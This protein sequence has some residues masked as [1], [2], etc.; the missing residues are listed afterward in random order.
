MASD[1]PA[2]RKELKAL[3]KQLRACQPPDEPPQYS[4]DVDL[5]ADNTHH[6]KDEQRNW[7]LDGLKHGFDVYVR[8]TVDL[9]RDKVRNLPTCLTRKLATTKWIFGN[10]ANHAIWGPFNKDMSDLP[11]WLKGKLRLS[12]IGAIKKGMHFLLPEHMKKWRVIHHLSHPRGGN[13]VNS[14]VL[15]EWATVQY[16]QFREVVELVHSLGVGALLWTVDAKDAYLRVP[17]NKS[18]MQYMGFSWEGMVFVFTC[19]S[20]GLASAPR[21][22]TLFADAMLSIIVNNSGVAEWWQWNGAPLVYHY[23]DDFFGG[24]PVGADF[25]SKAQFDAVIFWFIKLGVPTTAEKCVEPTTR[26]KILGF[27]Y[28]TIRQ[29]VFIPEGKKDEIQHELEAILAKNQVTKERMQSLVGK[30][31]WVSVCLFAGPAFVRRIEFEINKRRPGHHIKVALFS[32]DLEWWVEQL[33]ASADGIKFVDILRKRSNG[34]VNVWTDA[35]TGDGM[36]GWNKEGQW[37]RF[38][39]DDHERQELFPHP[40]QPDIYWKEMVAI[41]TAAM[42]W[43]HQWEGKAVTFW[44]DN[45]AC[46]W[47]L[48][49]KRCAFERTDVMELIR[50]IAACAN[51]MKFTPYFIHIAGKDNLTADALSRFDVAKF[52]AD[53]AGIEMD[54]DETEC[55]RIFTAL[56]ERSFPKGCPSKK[57]KRKKKGKKS[58]QKAAAAERG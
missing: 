18:S 15:G 47:S 21:I 12:P 53:T 13:S 43:G 23:I 58:K 19:L 40:Q 34:D 28:D 32:E 39:W 5:W 33:A 50:V 35:S 27:I 38:K 17:I 45:E 29:M 41:A 8:P 22:Y 20:F 36:G 6:L 54:S 11:E 4:F 14:E 24:A 9:A 44:I 48:I 25:E 7:L 56:L 49:K 55:H 37:F 42:I 26:I 30:L 31:R 51:K 52:K 2:M 57:E 46:V 10:M 16:V 1:A 3:G